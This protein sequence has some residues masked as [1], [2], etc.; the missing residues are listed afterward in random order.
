LTVRAV[1]E[2]EERTLTDDEIESYR[3]ALAERAE[4]DLG[5]RLRGAG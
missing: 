1:L 3:R 5:V 2:P 4:R